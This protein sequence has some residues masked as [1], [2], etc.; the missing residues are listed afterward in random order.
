MADPTLA[1]A[2]D[3]GYAACLDFYFPRYCDSADRSK[4]ENPFYDSNCPNNEPR[5]THS[6]SAKT[7]A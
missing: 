1:E 6:S 3:A 5:E 2:R 7:S 4:P